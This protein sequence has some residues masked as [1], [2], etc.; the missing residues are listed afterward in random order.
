MTFS[1]MCA[2][3]FDQINGPLSSLLLFLL[4]LI[5]FLFPSNSAFYFHVPFLHVCVCD[6]VRSIGVAYWSTGK[7][8][9][10]GTWVS[11]Q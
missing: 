5:L 11:H 10:I 4:L 7:Q 6:P 2:G 9:F 1:Y 3:N 8:S